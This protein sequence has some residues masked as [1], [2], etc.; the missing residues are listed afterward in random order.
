MYSRQLEMDK[1]R[2]AL[3]SS[4]VNIFISDDEQ[5]DGSFNARIQR[6]TAFQMRRDLSLEPL[7][8][9]PLTLS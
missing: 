1:Q 7:T 8:L 4:Y 5:T 3:S 9:E 6:D 2:G